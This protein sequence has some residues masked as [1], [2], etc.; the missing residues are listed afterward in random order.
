[1]ELSLPAS[2][3]TN[4]RYTPSFC[5]HPS[6]ASSPLPRDPPRGL[7]SLPSSPRSG[8]AA[9]PRPPPPPPQPPVP[10]EL[11][12]DGAE[13]ERETAAPLEAVLQVSQASTHGSPA[14][15][16]GQDQPD[17]EGH[18]AV[19]LGAVH[20]TALLEG[21]EKESHTLVVRLPL[22]RQVPRRGRPR[23]LPPR[24]AHL[25]EPPAPPRPPPGRDPP[26]CRGDTHS[27]CAL[28]PS[29]PPPP[30]GPPLCGPPRAPRRP[31]PLA[32]CGTAL[33]L[34]TARRR[35]PDMHGGS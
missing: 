5:D 25:R 24:A 23:R 30:P 28:L 6:S 1:M 20:L 4:L 8:R 19:P 17:P 9:R 2:I 10:E 16:A 27:A 12:E 34:R 22:G 31:P 29:P 7:S 21:R 18:L 13:A 32:R 15:A 11:P 3:G 26:G 33:R 35:L 14:A